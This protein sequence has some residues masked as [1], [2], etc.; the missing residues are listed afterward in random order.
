MAAQNCMWLV[1]LLRSQKGLGSNLGS[2]IA[3][4]GL[5]I[6]TYGYLGYLTRSENIQVETHSKLA[7]GVKMDANDVFFCSR[8]SL[9]GAWFR[10]TDKK[11]CKC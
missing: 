8:I 1:H 4:C 5:C 3:V 11:T 2:G 10:T 9:I 6:F 7:L